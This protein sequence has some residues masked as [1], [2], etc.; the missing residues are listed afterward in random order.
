LSEEVQ[1]KLSQQ[2]QSSKHD[3]IKLAKKDQ[4]SKKKANKGE[5]NK[6]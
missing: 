1:R 6:K 3:K 2:R 5:K 4:V